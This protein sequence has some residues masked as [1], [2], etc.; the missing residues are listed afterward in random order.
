M[1]Q[2]ELLK[3]AVEIYS[4]THETEK[5]GKFLVESMIELGFD[6]AY[7]DKVGN[8]VG[9]IGSGDKTILMLGHMDTVAGEIDVKETKGKLFGRGSIDAKGPLCSFIS[10]AAN[11]K[12]EL[13]AKVIVV[14]A[15]DEEGPSNGAEFICKNMGIKPDFIIIGEPFGTNGITL[16]YKGRLM[17]EFKLE[18]ECSHS[19]SGELSS[20]DV[21]VEFYTVLRAMA[22][23]HNEGKSIFEKLDICILG[24]NSEN[25]GIADKVELKVAYRIP[26]NM[27]VAEVKKQV[28][29]Q[30]PDNCRI[31]FSWDCEPIKASKQNDLVKCFL[32]SIRKNKLDP[33]F[34]V[35]TGTSD[36]NILGNCFNCPIVTYGPGDSS[37]D[38]TPNEHIVL[39]DYYRSITVLQ[40]VL[41]SLA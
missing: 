35:K 15:Y 25:D 41:L 2:K 19:A 31:K 22:E 16:G 9:E 32:T 11:V 18:K 8:A 6:K 14:G 26:P 40:D 20:S 39:D 21:A 27:D 10:A 33:K 5:I 23:L 28:N 38:H 36:M 37:L 1:E 13:N 7:V 30:K 4:P 3:K 24:I 17:F 34:K 12:K 29:E